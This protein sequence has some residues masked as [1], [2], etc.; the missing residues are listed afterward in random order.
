LRMADL[1]GGLGDAAIA[2]RL[3]G[4]LGDQGLDAHVRARAADAL[5]TLDLDG[6]ATEVKTLAANPG[7]DALVRGRAAGCLAQAE[8]GVAW[9]IELLDREDIGEE[10][11]LALYRAAQ[12]AGVRVFRADGGYQ[13]LPLQPMQVA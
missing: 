10:V 3:F 8:Q 4:L 5:S 11:Y 7:V 1:L 13:V 12:Q 9:L 6:L 2:R